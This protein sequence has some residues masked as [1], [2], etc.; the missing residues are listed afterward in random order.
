M[1]GWGMGLGRGGGADSRLLVVLPAPGCGLSRPKA[2]KGRYSSFDRGWV[3][4]SV[5]V[6]AGSDRKSSGSSSL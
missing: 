1:G 3:P 2:G 4:R 5:T 6:P